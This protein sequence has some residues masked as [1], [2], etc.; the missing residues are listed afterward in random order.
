MHFCGIIACME[1][2]TETK[3]TL[4]KEAALLDSEMDAIIEAN[5][6]TETASVRVEKGPQFEQEKSAHEDEEHRRTGAGRHQSTATIEPL[7]GRVATPHTKSERLVEIEKV[8]S[9]GLESIYASLDAPTQQKVRAEGE[10]AARGIEKIIE[11]GTYAAGK[12]L[13]II[14]KWIKHIP[15][16]N[17]F[18]LEQ[19]S[20][21]KTD[22]ILAIARKTREHE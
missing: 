16:V 2:K 14:R 20:K 22:K 1:L 7:S 10:D 4:F 12:I 18:F 6:P 3:K 19:E 11:A 13:S 8:M 21:I 15:G 17:Q 9:D 5:R